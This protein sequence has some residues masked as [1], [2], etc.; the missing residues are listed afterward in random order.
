MRI[1]G[2]NRS[3]L[4]ICAAA[5]MLA[6]C[7]GSQPPIGAPGAMPQTSARATHA[8]RGKSWMLPEAK[9]EDLIYLSAP[10]GVYV[11]TYP[12]G[13]H[14]GTLTGFGYP[15][16]ECADKSGDVFIIIVDG[17]QQGVYEYTHGGSE[18]INFLPRTG[19]YACSV[20]P[21]T[22]NLAVIAQFGGNVYVY[23]N[24]QGT[25]TVYSNDIYL[26]TSPAYDSS[27]NLFVD[28]EYQ[29]SG[30]ALEEL[31][32]GG[33]TFEDIKVQGSFD[34][35]SYEPI[36]WNGK[37]LGLGTRQLAKHGRRWSRTVVDR[38][39]ISGTTGIVVGEAPLSLQ[40]E[41]AFPQWWV[42]NGVAIQASDKHGVP[43]Y[44]AYFKYPG[45]KKLKKVRMPGIYLVVGTVL[46]VA[47]S[48]TRPAGSAAWR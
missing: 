10:T 2:F 25:P 3:A 43:S 29:E 47:P 11:Y 33:G 38:I 16:Y 42:S 41:A 15:L 39:Q 36:L 34:G 7:G 6:G 21:T 31:P 30:F 4:L 27:G 8:D 14:V 32:Q 5:A 22:G 1:L 17:S 9:A 18:P 44:F 24:A 23:A 48:G 13:K 46:S 40:H 28:G 19:A 37:Y 35:D 20:D 26:M 45:G 12:K